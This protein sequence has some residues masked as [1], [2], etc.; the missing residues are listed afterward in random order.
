MIKKVNQYTSYSQ[1]LWSYR[2]SCCK[3]PPVK[4]ALQVTLCNLEPVKQEQSTEAATLRLLCSQPSSN[5]SCGRQWH[6][7]KPA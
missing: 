2:C 3:C 4:C 1:W 6:F 5:V 7:Q